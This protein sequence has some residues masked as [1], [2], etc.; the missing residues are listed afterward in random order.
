MCKS[1][2]RVLETNSQR[3]C[4]SCD[5]KPYIIWRNRMTNYIWCPK[6]LRKQ[7]TDHITK[8]DWIEAGKLLQSHRKQEEALEGIMEYADDQANLEEF[9]SSDANL[10]AYDHKT[11]TPHIP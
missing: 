2:N 7:I 3:K 6:C 5:V 1:C 11:F 9:N 10:E 4:D 8:D